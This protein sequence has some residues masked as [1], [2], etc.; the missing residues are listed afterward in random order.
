MGTTLDYYNLIA[1]GYD[2]SDGFGEN[3]RYFSAYFHEIAADLPVKNGRVLDVCVGTGILSEPFLGD[4][5]WDVYGVDGAPAMLEKCFEKGFA[6]ENLELANLNQEKLPFPDDT[7]DLIFCQ[8]GLGYLRDGC[9]VVADMLRVAKPSGFVL[10]NNMHAR[11]NIGPIMD[12]SADD[13]EEGY[14]E[15]TLYNHPDTHIETA[16]SNNNAII[17]DKQLI[18]TFSDY[19]DYHACDLTYENFLFVLQPRPSPAP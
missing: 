3:S 10:F 11:E 2:Q 6:P 14:F 5:A 9:R 16:I 1:D 17:I 15:Y 8:G 7:F 18:N 4:P 13:Y 19:S 12:H